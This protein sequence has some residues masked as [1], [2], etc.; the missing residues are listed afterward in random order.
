MI[1]NEPRRTEHREKLNIFPF[2]VSRT[3]DAQQSKA[4]AKLIQ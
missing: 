1:G 2:L 3:V 4:A